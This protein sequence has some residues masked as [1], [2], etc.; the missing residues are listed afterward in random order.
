MDKFQLIMR[1]KYVIFIVA[2]FLFQTVCKGQ[3]GSTEDFKPAT[4]NQQGKNYPQVNSQNQV[5]AS[6]SAPEANKVQLD[7]GGMKYNMVK[8]EKG[9][10][11][12]ES[13]SQDEGFHY[14]QLVIDGAFVPDPGSRFF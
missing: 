12:G 4:T 5:R 2:A 6:I 9:V 13:L 1:L 3:A 14:Y 10:W 7:I 8:D 11:V